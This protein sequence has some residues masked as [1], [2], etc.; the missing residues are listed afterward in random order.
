MQFISHE[1]GRAR[2]ALHKYTNGATGY[3]FEYDYFLKDHLGNTRIVLTQEKDTAKYMATMEAAYRTTE[4]QLFYNIPQSSYARASVA[5]YPTDNTTS[6]NDS[7]ARVNGSGQNVGPSIILK[8]MSGDVVDIACKSYWVANSSTTTLPSITNVLN[9][10]ANGIEAITGG[11]HGT[12]GQ[13]NTTGSPLYTALNTFI[14]NNDPAI[15]NKPKAYLNWILLDDQF[16]Y[17]NS[18][19]QSG[20]IPVSNFAAGTLGTP[21]YTGIPITKSGYLYI[22]V[23][24]ESQ[25]W[26]VF[27]DNLT[28]QQRSGPITEETH[29][30]PFGL[31][32]AGISD[33]AAGGLTN[34]YKFGGKELQNQEFSDGTGLEA[35]DFKARMQDPQ[36]GRWWQ[37]DPLADK[38]RR[39]SPY[40]FAFDNPLR[41]A[42]P[43]GMEAD[44]IIVLRQKSKSGHSSGHQ[45]VLIGDDKNGWKFYS[46]D[47]AASSGG[48]GSSGPGHSTNGL[49]F[50]TVKEFANSSYNTFKGNYAD[51]KGK[52]TSETDTK[53]SVLQRF[54][55]GYRIKTDVATDKK[56][57]AAAEKEIGT[58]YVLGFKDCTGVPT[59]ALDAGNLNNGESSGLGI[60]NNA[61]GEEVRD[62]NWLPSTKQAEIEKSNPGARVDNE[63]VPAPV[64]LPVT[65]IKPTYTDNTGVFHTPLKELPNQ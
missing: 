47:G 14:T 64:T 32:M 46:K 16:N 2:W 63:L 35:Y 26:D 58:S 45:A 53:G 11:S 33:K 19:P 37:I 3:G 57:E 40:N 61:T 13:L 20:A 28:I 54:T 62:M 60:V 55:D 43:D 56:M 51:G 36:L 29:Y 65:P 31:T 50:K 34:K 23:S 42:D 4:N 49:P 38:M 30:Y 27:F 7:V 17:V 1:E 44:D 10:L 18:Y 8:V 24:N 9:S 52:E 41:F 48:G 5:G 25:N 12:L 15:T 39:F 6:P 59:K 22:Y 21:G